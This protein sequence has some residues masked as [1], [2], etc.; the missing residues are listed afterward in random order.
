MAMLS[1]DL[2]DSL[3]KLLF[4]TRIKRSSSFIK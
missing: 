2:K 3:E 1:I 4:V